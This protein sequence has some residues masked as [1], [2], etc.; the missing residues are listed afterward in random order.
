[1]MIK[2]TKES[3]ARIEIRMSAQEKEQIQSKARKCGLS[4]TEYVKIRYNKL[5]KFLIAKK[6]DIVCRLW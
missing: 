2:K 3:H 1:M 5:R 6:K 4:T